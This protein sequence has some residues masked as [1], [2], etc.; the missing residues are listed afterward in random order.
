VIALWL[1]IKGLMAGMA[2][3]APVGPIN[4]LCASRTLSKGRTSGLLSGLGAATADALYGAVAAF[5]ITLV[6]DFLRQQQF[7]IRVVGGVLLVMI[8][9]IYVRK[10]P[11]EIKREDAGESAHSDY[12]STLLLTLTNPTT[13]LSY[14]A[15]LTALGMADQRAWWLSFLLVAGI[16]SGSMLWWII[17]VLIVDRLRDR[18]TDRT[19]CWMNR[20]AGVAIGGFGLVTFA[21]GISSRR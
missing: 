3:A 14:L 13:V 12:A 9:V 1:L 5:S 20:I 21:I 8:G 15:V 19:V 16:F 2:I 10:P 4:V 7:W 11:Q 6:I 17:L 18:F